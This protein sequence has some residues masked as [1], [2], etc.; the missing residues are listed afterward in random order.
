MT[1][2][3][4]TF[5]VGPHFCL[6]HALARVE[7]QEALSALIL[8]APGLRPAVALEDVPWTTEG[9]THQPLRLPVELA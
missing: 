5:G 2:P 3:H 9:L 8:R 1:R 7:L 4:L 6:G